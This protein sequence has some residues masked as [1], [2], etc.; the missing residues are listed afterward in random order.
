MTGSDCT[1][2]TGK[3]YCKDYGFIF[4]MNSSEATTVPAFCNQDTDCPDA[5]G[6][7]TSDDKFTKICYKNK[8]YRGVMGSYDSQYPNMTVFESLMISDWDNVSCI[9][10]EGSIDECNLDPDCTGFR[11]QIDSSKKSYG[12]KGFPP[13]PSSYDYDLL[14]DFQQQIIRIKPEAFNMSSD[15]GSCVAETSDCNVNNCFKCEPNNP[16]NCASCDSG[17]TAN[18]DKTQCISDCLIYNCNKCEPGTTD[19][20]KTCDT[21]YTPSKDK[22]SCVKKSDKESNTKWV[23]I[24]LIVVGILFVLI[25]LIIFLVGHFKDKSK[26]KPKPKTIQQ[27]PKPRSTV[28]VKPKKRRTTQVSFRPKPKPKPKPRITPTEVP[29]QKQYRGAEIITTIE[30]S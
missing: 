18:D 7:T 5:Y 13:H 30:K 3:L 4:P 10:S 21:D 9:Y 8:C 23:I 14:A 1:P 28:S 27:K 17:Y 26:T 12:Y 11:H 2:Q 25:A 15:F 6:I 19:I 22:T 20:C 24:G 16:V 29:Q